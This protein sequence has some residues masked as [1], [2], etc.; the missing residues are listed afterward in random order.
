MTSTTSQAMLNQQGLFDQNQ[1]QA[2]I[3]MGFFSYPPNNLTFSSLGCQ[4]SLKALSSLPSS[5]GSDDHHAASTNLSETLIPSLNTPLKHRE[6]HI[7]SDFG[8]SQHLSLQRSSA[9]LWSWGDQVSE[10]LSS[11]R[12][13][14]DIHDH[15]HVGLGVSAMKMKKIKA[16]RRKVREPRF[17]F[18]TMS[19]VDVL[20]DG[21]KWRK[22]GQKVV[23]NTQHPRSYYRCTMDNCRVKKRVERLAEDP[24]M[25]ITT[26]E[27]RHVHSP[28]H[29][30]E[31]SQSPSHLNNFFW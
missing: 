13:S 8:G 11:K 3:Q 30:L 5:L 18:K 20:D 7:T 14:G 17:C 1:D 28:S 25:V 16:I 6:A 22:Y 29:D 31:D 2:P 21:Y 26:Y 15:H 4:Q 27:G 10:C 19:E 23:K 12:S 9:N 24:R